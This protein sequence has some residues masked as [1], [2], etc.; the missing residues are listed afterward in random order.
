ML[1]QVEMDVCIPYELDPAHIDALKAEEKVRAQV[2]Q[3]QGKWRHLW[4]VVGAYRNTSI[5]DTENAA[6]LHTILSTL[7]LFPFM[8]IKV[9]ALC[10][11]PSSI[12]ADDR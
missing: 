3:T 5:F 8:K 10:R 11:H 12:H 2:L 9:T 7:P 4:R 6:E 1:F